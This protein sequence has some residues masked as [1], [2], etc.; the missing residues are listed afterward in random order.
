M[1]FDSIYSLVGRE[2]EDKT[3]IYHYSDGKKDSLKTGNTNTDNNYHLLRNA[4]EKKEGLQ[5]G[6]YHIPEKPEDDEDN[7]DQDEQERE[8]VY[9]ILEGPTPE[10]ETEETGDDTVQQVNEAAVYEVPIVS[11]TKNNSEHTNA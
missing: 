6:L 10:R 8:N 5:D 9:Y 7:E 11:S 3:N 2:E 1:S 4:Q